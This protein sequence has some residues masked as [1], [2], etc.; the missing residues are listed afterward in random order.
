MEI[1]EKLV[2]C[3]IVMLYVF[4]AFVKYPEV[5]QSLTRS[6]WAGTKT[7]LS[8]DIAIAYLPVGEPPIEG[9][10]SENAIR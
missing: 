3:M 4:W 7:R 6:L 1:V 8:L 5:A 2:T 10:V 9:W